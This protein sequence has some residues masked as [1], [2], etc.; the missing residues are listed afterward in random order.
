MPTT[1]AERTI[2]AL[3]DAIVPSP[4]A[5]E[6]AGAA[7]VAA[8]RFVLHYL[9]LVRPGLSDALT[10]AL[11]GMAAVRQGVPPAEGVFEG[12]DPAARLEVVAALGRHENHEMRDLIGVA[13]ALV[14]A[15][16]YGEWTGY[17]DAGALTRK[18]I[19]WVLCRHD[20]PARSVPGL[21]APRT[22]S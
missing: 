6:T 12:L 1:V 10:A 5:D 11:D 16:F 22:T 8:E 13:S 17:D 4:P 20:G 21:L 2:A 14:V 9:E 7:D 19:G 18:P 3:A 15:A